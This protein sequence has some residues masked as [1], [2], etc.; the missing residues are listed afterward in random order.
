MAD[1]NAGEVCRFEVCVVLAHLQGVA[2]ELRV[3]AKGRDELF[4]VAADTALEKRIDRHQ[5]PFLVFKISVLHLLTSPEHG[6]KASRRSPDT[7]PD[8]T[9]TIRT[10]GKVD[11]NN[12]ASRVKSS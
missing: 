1:E 3:F 5:R 10:P 7:A 4:P 9:S 8:Q 11:R 6:Q 2:G 12:L